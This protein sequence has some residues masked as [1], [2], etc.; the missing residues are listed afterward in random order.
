VFLALPTG[1]LLAAATSGLS[2]LFGLGQKEQELGQ[3]QLD[4]PMTAAQ[5]YSKLMQGLNIPTGETKQTVGSTGYT[6]S[7]LAQITGLL[8]ALGSFASPGS[9]TTVSPSAVNPAG[10]STVNKPSTLTVAEGGA[11]RSEAPT[12]SANIPAGAAYHD[13]QGNFYDADG[14]LVR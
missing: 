13:G 3:K 11:I 14:N 2:N 5:N 12:A 10:S 1:A 7:P 9:T 8:A 6:T 4:Y